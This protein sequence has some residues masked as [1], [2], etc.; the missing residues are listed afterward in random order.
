[1]KR[2]LWDAKQAEILAAETKKQEE[3]AKQK[4]KEM[5]EAEKEAAKQKEKENAESISKLIEVSKLIQE[6][7][8]NQDKEALDAGELKVNRSEDGAEAIV[9]DENAIT[10]ENAINTAKKPAATKD[11]IEATRD[12]QYESVDKLEQDPIS[13]GTKKS[14]SKKPAGKKPS[15]KKVVKK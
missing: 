13:E 7:K 9:V 3:L 12:S 5:K 10:D 8:A 1:M 6:S 2:A 4:E 11:P 14:A 15:A